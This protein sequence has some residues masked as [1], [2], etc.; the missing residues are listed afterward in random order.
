MS[1]SDLSSRN[2]EKDVEH[3]YGQAHP[4]RDPVKQ[5]RRIIVKVCSHRQ[6]AALDV[7]F[8][9]LQARA[10]AWTWAQL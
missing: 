7:F 10:C 9:H 4:S 2:F 6:H 1:F 3:V 8:G 5:A